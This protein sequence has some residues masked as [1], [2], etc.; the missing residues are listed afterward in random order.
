LHYIGTALHCTG[1]AHLG[2]ALHVCTHVH[3]EENTPRA[4]QSVEV[5]LVMHLVHFCFL[6]ILMRF[7]GVSWDF[8]GR[9]STP[10]E[11][12]QQNT[13]NIQHSCFGLLL[14]PI[15]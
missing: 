11:T 14:T 2:T 12:L 1:T 5:D 3:C 4:R 13:R 10:K 7:F 8:S 6:T 15:I 9:T